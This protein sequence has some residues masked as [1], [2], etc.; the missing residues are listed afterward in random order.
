MIK[1]PRVRQALMDE[2]GRPIASGDAIELASVSDPPVTAR[3]KSVSLD[4]AQR[5][6]Q[7]IE[8]QIVIEKECCSID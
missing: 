8:L 3:D 2:R 7:N 5:Q 1:H 4:T 6:K